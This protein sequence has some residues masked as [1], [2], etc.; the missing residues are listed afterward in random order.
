MKRYI[1]KLAAL[2]MILGASHSPAQSVPSLVNY[3]GRLTDQTGAPLPAGPYTVQ[4]R[5]WNDPS[6]TGGNNLIWAQQQSVVIQSN[7]VFDV[8]LGSP[9]GTGVPGATP[10]VNNIAYAFSGSNCFLG[11]TLT[12]SNGATIFYPTEIL[13]R[14]QLLSVPYALMAQ[15]TE[16]ASLTIT[17]FS[18]QLALDVIIPPGTISALGGTNLP[19]GWLLCDGSVQSSSSYPRLYNAISTN[20]GAGTSGGIAGTND[21]NLPD[22]RGLFLRGANGLRNDKFA[23]PDSASRTTN[24][25]GGSSG[26]AVGSVQAD[27]VGSHQHYQSTGPNVLQP[28]SGDT[29]PY[30]SGYTT[31]VV[32]SSSGPGIGA[33]TRPKNAYVNYIIKY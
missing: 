23:D 4:F 3:Q 13:P 27:I 17:N 11:L 22:L 31:T 28:G 18:A 9:G 20:W 33:E 19:S 24:S 25:D 32:V 6:A 12:V 29:T 14:E 16:P 8:I 30:G 26:N 2:G 10:A 21:F 15:Q 5:L 1:I 7:G